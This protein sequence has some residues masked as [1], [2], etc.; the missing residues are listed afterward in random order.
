ML[1]FLQYALFAHSLCNY[2]VY[3]SKRNRSSS[4]KKLKM[5]QINPKTLTK[6][7]Y[8]LF[9]FSGVCLS[10]FIIGLYGYSI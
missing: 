5:I 10:G 2:L 8:S 1:P 6:A 7:V 9:F 3:T 4:H